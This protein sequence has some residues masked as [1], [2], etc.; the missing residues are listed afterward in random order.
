MIST[1]LERISFEDRESWLKGRNTQGIGASEAAIVLGVSKWSTPL[2]L[3]KQKR[4]IAPQKDI[5]NNPAVAFGVLSEPHIRALFQIQHPELEVEYHEFDLLYQTER[6][7]LFATLDG[8]LTDKETGAKGVLEIKTASPQSREDWRAWDGQTPYYPQVCHQ[9]L[10][11]GY[12]FVYLYALLMGGEGKGYLRTYL[13]T[14]KNAKDDMEY[15]LSA[16]ERFYSENI[17]GGKMPSAKLKI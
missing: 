14:R 17:I 5:S 8:E 3:W 2:E 12:D 13:Y 11:T 16:E 6:P 9:L 15:L 1:A 4:G 10:A 7:W